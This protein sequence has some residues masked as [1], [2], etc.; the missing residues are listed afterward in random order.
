MLLGGWWGR[1]TAPEAIRLADEALARSSSKR[2]EAYARVVGGAAVAVSGRLDEGREKIDAGRALFQ[3]LGD[4]MAWA[5]ITAL[6]AE[7]ELVAGAP[8]R[9]HDALSAAAAALAARSET[10]YRATTLSFQ[11]HAALDLGRR[12]EAAQ[13]ADEALAIAAA[14]DFDPHARSNYVLARVAAQTGKVAEAERLLA[15]ASA[16]IEPTDFVSLHFDLALARADVARHAGRDAEAR[17]ALEHALALAEQKA[18]VL[19]AD[20]ARQELASLAG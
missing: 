15:A 9:A 17:E 10:G 6:V 16:R 5:G 8:Q 2:L 4:I 19:G 7:V 18:S 13:L 1:T 3:D 11:A 20:R 14:D 12:D